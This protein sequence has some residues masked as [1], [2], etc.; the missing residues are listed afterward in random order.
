M[1]AR[2]PDGDV[3]MGLQSILG[4]WENGITENQMRM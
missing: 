2:G 3:K 4:A 1:I